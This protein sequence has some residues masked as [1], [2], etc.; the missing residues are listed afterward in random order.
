MATG[1]TAKE[2]MAASSWVRVSEAALGLA[3]RRLSP[4]SVLAHWNSWEGAEASSLPEPDLKT[5]QRLVVNVQL[6][7]EH[8]MTTM[9]KRST[10]S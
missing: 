4:S 3:L 2:H 8:W 1:I 10:V 5:S 6:G 7:T 9:T